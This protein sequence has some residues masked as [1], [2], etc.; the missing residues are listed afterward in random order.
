MGNA[1][2]EELLAHAKTASKPS[3]LKITDI[4]ICEIG[5]SF[6]T[7]VIKILT[8]QGI[9]GYGQVREH[10]AA[11]FAVMLKR[12]LIGENPCN[13]DKLFR[14]IKQ[15]GW[16]SHQGGGV[17]G[18]EVALWDLAGKA[19][20]IPVWQLLGGK[21]RDKVR[22]YCDTDI[23]GKHDGTAMGKVLKERIDT[24]GYNVVKMDLSADELCF[25]VP[26]ATTL[27]TDTLKQFDMDADFDYRAFSRSI[28]DP[29]LDKAKRHEMIKMRN[30]RVYRECVPGSQRGIHLTEYGLDIMEE[31]VKQVR[32]VVGIQIP[33]A[34]DH[35][36]P[37]SV[38]SCI[39]LAKRLEKY[40]LAWLEDMVPWM[41][42]DDLAEIQRNTTAPLCTGED[43]YLKENYED[44]F[45]KRSIRLVHPDIISVGGIYECK[46]VGDMAQDYGI[47]MVIHMNETPIAAMAAAHA[48]AAT[49]NFFA[50]E[51]H[52]HDMKDYCDMI[53]TRDDHIV[54]NGYINVPEEPGLGILALNDEW[55]KENLA[56]H[57]EGKVWQDTD[58][59][60]Y[61]Q[62]RDR[63]WL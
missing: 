24:M 60:D 9:E 32:D 11:V 20:G 29:G 33:I 42:A 41:Q 37:I 30:D 52:H 13:V 31:Y 10:S 46:K 4:K 36:G 59:W 48:A 23:H 34:T 5:R 27:P 45:E 17:S 28:N 62:S 8:N 49:E 35:F 2:F 57:C 39:Q 1:R 38:G 26:G 14:R 7:A 56:P 55:L 22:I 50:Q 40:N 53:V 25:G 61:W 47:Q 12:L 15:F 51:F 16:H 3:E 44:L 43:I 54:Q 63:I 19:Y 18:I 58:N 6:G 21:F